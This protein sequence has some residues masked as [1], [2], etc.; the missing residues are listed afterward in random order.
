[1]SENINLTY[2]VFS[3]G[4]ATENGELSSSL[5]AKGNIYLDLR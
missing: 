2:N 1:M 5:Y 3:T 4:Q